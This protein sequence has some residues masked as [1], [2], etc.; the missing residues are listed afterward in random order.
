LAPVIFFTIWGNR[1][2]HNWALITAFVAAIAGGALY[3]LESAAYTNIL[4]PLFGYSHK[5][6]KL[7]IICICILIIGCGAF[8][9]ALKPVINKPLDAR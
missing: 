6:S 4:E 9:L 8:F 5:Y 1:N 3:M 7:L 2:V